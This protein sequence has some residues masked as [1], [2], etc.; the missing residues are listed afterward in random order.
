LS[1]PEPP[2]RGSS[3]VA[4]LQ[5]LRLPAVFT[6]AA[7]I[8]L[9]FLITYDPHAVRWHL[10]GLLL[11]AS[12]LLYWSGMVLNDVCDVEQDR[13]QRPHRPIPSGRVSLSAARWVGAELLLLGTALG[14][15]ASYF[16]GTWRPAAVAAALAACVL[17]YD[18][19]LKRTPV[20]PVAMGACR[21]LNVLLGMSAAA[22]SWNVAH[23]WLAGSI[24]TY[25]AGVTW[26]ARHEAEPRGRAALVAGFVVL[27]AG[28]GLLAAF[29]TV[30][31][32]QAWG[33]IDALLPRWYLLLALLGIMIAWR[34]L[35]AIAIP[36]PHN[37][38]RAVQQCLMSLVILDAAAVIPV[39]GVLYAIP[40][41][42]LVVPSVLLGR[43]LYAT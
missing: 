28:I 32:R 1:A 31:Q 36:E 25:I 21:F 33:V 10:L 18:A 9:G 5:L 2:T 42:V 24:A 8:L 6:A 35:W 29:P 15:S 22:V 4:W 19:V 26:F 7:D 12:A 20:G 38:Q 23:Y 40:I 27:M 43:W 14:C 13:R 41:L 34:P 11:G 17:L 30:A 3:A 39:R 37:I 16:A